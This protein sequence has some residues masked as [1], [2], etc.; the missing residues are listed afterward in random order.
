MRV[1]LTCGNLLPHGDIFRHTDTKLSSMCISVSQLF[2]GACSTAL[3]PFHWVP[4][5][6]PYQFPVVLNS[7]CCHLQRKCCCAC[8]ICMC[9]SCRAH[10]LALTPS[11][12]DKAAYNKI[13]MQEAVWHF[14]MQTGARS[15]HNVCHEQPRQLPV[16]VP[17]TLCCVEGICDMCAQML[18]GA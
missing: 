11:A 16:A 1:E 3:Q 9:L 17:G 7:F 10:P 6:G 15:P 2:T 12:S 18:P 8:C 14:Y 4:Q 13:H 5:A